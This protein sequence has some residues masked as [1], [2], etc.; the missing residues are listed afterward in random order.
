MGLSFCFC[1]LLPALLSCRLRRRDRARSQELA[2]YG[3]RSRALRPSARPLEDAAV[4]E[5]DSGRRH[6]RTESCVTTTDVT[7]Q[8]RLQVDDHLV[9]LLRC[10]RVESRGSGS[11]EDHLGVDDRSTAPGDRCAWP[12][13]STGISCSVFGRF[14]SS[15]RSRT[16]A[17]FPS[18]SPY[19]AGGNA[20]FLEDSHRVK[21]RAAT[22]IASRL[23]ADHK[24][25]SS[26]GRWM[27][28][29][30]TSTRPWPAPRGDMCRSVTDFPFPSSRMT[31]HFA[32]I[33]LQVPPQEPASP[34]ACGSPNSTKRRGDLLGGRP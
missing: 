23:H 9:Y 10:E 15:I 19:A 12:P 27:S 4:E 28:S 1:L 33:H 26:A 7:F 34:V 5:C 3:G 17:D 11:S 29:S 20:M 16:R 21:Q 13:E 6:N 25:S 24:S 14:T 30:S 8:F 22:G 2:H 31:T 32:A 18:S